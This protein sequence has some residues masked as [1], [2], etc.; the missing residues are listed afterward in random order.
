[1]KGWA[2][3]G[4]RMLVLCIIKCWFLLVKGKQVSR[5]RSLLII[6]SSYLGDTDLLAWVFISREKNVALLLSL[7]GGG[8]QSLL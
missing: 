6:L 5:Q 3:G 4:Q 7:V 2:T 1:M 8:G